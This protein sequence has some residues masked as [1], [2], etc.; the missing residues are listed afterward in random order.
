M[1]TT[2]LSLFDHAPKGK[3]SIVCLGTPRGGTSM[4]AGAIAG[5]GVHMGTNLP[6][7]V[8]DDLFNPDV[9]GSDGPEFIEQVSTEIAHRSAIH[10]VWGWK[11]PRASRYLPKVAHL[12]PSPRLVVVFRDPVPAA[13]RTARRNSQ[14]NAIRATV[15][16]KLRSELQNLNMCFELGYPTLLVSFEKA[17]AHPEAFLEDLSAFT[18][19][20]VPDN[21]SPILDFMTP[22]SYKDVSTLFTQPVM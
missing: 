8:E 21:V 13:I 7:N 6:V 10:D 3:R 9:F 12:L 5:L 1:F 14:A 20:P 18:G 11:Y 19:M 2:S 16:G 17:Q 22:G 15:A 4:V